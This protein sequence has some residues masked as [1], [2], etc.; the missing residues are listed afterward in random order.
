MAFLTDP[1]SAGHRIMSV[2]PKKNPTCYFEGPK[3]RKSIWAHNP[4]EP[5][6]P[7]V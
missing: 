6:T 2:L 5:Q 7:G 3:L 1:S 4:S